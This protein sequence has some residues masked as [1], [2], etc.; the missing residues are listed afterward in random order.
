MPEGRT[1]GCRRRYSF[2]AAFVAT[3]AIMPA[4]A[5]TNGNSHPV[6]EFQGL[7]WM[8]VDMSTRIEA[9]RTLIHRA[10]ANAGDGFPDVT[11][12]AQAKIFAFERAIDVTNDALQM[13]GAADYSRARTLER[14]VCDA[15]MFTIGGGTAPILRTVVASRLLGRKL[16]QTRDGYL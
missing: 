16:P 7:Q 12:A 6:C 2:A 10:A 11:E 5:Q 4:A 15:R 9:T 1:H 14:M 8:L 3:L 13:F